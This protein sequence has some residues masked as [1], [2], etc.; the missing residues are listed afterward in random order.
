MSTARA[1]P[2]SDGQRVRRA[3][4]CQAPTQNG[5]AI[6]EPAANAIVGS[7]FHVLAL[8][9]TGATWRFELWDINSGTK[10]LTVRNSGYMSCSVS[11][12][13]GQHWLRFISRREDGYQV[14][15]DRYVNVQ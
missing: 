5:I 4:D 10:L 2:A 15:A 6:C 9:K 12:G 1:E 7:P 13:T 14:S 8:A 11:L 3:G